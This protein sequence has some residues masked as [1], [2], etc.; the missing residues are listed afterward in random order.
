MMPLHKLAAAAIGTLLLAFAF[1]P[2]ARSDDG[3]ALFKQKCAACHGPDGAGQTGMGK[4]M[5]LRDLGSAD[6]QKQ[7]DAE[8]TDIIVNG[9]NKMPAYKG[10]L[11]DDQVKQVVAFI[12]SLKK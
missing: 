4:T 9:K 6:V 2:A 7:S 1:V 8:L 5:K 12:R 3:A 11:T 10:K